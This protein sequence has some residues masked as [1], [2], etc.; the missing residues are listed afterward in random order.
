MLK[1]IKWGLIGVVGLSVTTYFFFGNNALNYASTM[2]GSVKESVRGQIPIEFEL[3]RAE[4][5]IKDIR[6]QIQQCKR[7]VALQEVQLDNLNADVARLERAVGR[8]ERKLKGGAEMLADSSGQASYELAGGVYSRERVEIDLERTFDSYRQNGTLLNGKRALIE[9]Q[10]RAVSAARSKLDAVR[11]EEV[12]LVDLIGQLKTQ[13]AQVD[14]LKASSHNFVL[15]DTALGQAKQV[16]AE[17]K[18]RLDVAQKMLA[19][20]MFFQDGIGSDTRPSR[21]IV[22]EIRH[23]FTEG[24]QH[25]A[26]TDG[27]EGEAAAIVQR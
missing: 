5:L 16:L 22:K 12:R 10:T 13:K 4:N 26:E 24:A 1:M 2:M 27:V 6:P 11:G 17:V 15:D 20:D 18:E 8:A 7:D 9:R 23:H 25:A 21:D 3:K 19:D 14:A